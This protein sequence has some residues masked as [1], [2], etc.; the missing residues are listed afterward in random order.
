MQQVVR[1]ALDAF[2]FMFRRRAFLHSYTAHGMEVAE[3]EE[4]Y[5]RLVA[6]ETEYQTLQ[7]ATASDNESDFDEEDDDEMY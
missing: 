5:E 3:F 1:R 2:A 6:L 4:A 7:D